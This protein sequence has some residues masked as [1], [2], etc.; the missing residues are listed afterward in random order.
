MLAPTPSHQPASLTL[1]LPAAGPVVVLAALFGLVGA[2]GT[3]T[4]VDYPNEGRAINVY[5]LKYGT[6]T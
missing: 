5:S 3:A 4:E 6:V 1:G 2:Q